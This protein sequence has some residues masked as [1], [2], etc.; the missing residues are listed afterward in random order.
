MGTV[1]N[2]N[3]RTSEWREKFINVVVEN[4][5][6]RHGLK[7]KRQENQKKAWNRF[8]IERIIEEWKT[9]IFDV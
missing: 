7:M 5:L 1:I 4:L 2:G 9:K 8:G 6:D 3:P